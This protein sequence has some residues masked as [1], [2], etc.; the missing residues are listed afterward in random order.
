MVEVTAEPSYGKTAPVSRIPARRLGIK[1]L[2]SARP[3]G[4]NPKGKCIGQAFLKQARVIHPLDL[5]FIRAAQKLQKP[6]NLFR[7]ISAFQGPPAFLGGT[8]R[9][10][11]L[12]RAFFD[13]V[14]V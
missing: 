2:E 13:L 6:Q 11:R 7:G 3:L 14:A 4:G 5:V 10:D 1:T 9:F 12:H 8:N